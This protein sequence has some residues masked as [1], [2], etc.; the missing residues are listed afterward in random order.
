[1][2]QKWVI[3]P[4]FY[5]NSIKIRNISLWSTERVK[6]RKIVLLESWEVLTIIN[7]FMQIKYLAYRDTSK[8][9]S[10]QKPSKCDQFSRTVRVPCQFIENEKNSWKFNIL[11]HTSLFRKNQLIP[12]PRVWVP[13][14][15]LVQ[16]KLRILYIF[17]KKMGDYMICWWHFF[18][19]WESAMNHH[20]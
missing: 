17:Q 10:H 1:M 12:K 11:H 20:S 5:N 6:R 18:S 16:L 2:E 8:S 7:R 4:N 13:D 19:K 9:F 14:P 15:S 3:R